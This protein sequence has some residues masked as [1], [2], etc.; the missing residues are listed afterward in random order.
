MRNV[1]TKQLPTKE[2]LQECFSYNDQT[3]ILTRKERP[4][5]HFESVKG[6]KI[7]LKKCQDNP[8]YMGWFDKDNYI[9]FSVTPFGHLLAHRVIFKMLHDREPEQ[10]DHINGKPWDNRP[11]N[12]READS[13]VN[14]RNTKRVTKNKSTGIIGVYL[15]VDERNNRRY[16]ATWFN[17]SGKMNSKSFS[18]NKLGEDVAYDLACKHRQDMINYLN[19]LGAGYTE[20]HSYN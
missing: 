13:F 1:K 17:L 20:R 2:Y 6:W 19:S 15:R 10:I 8:D 12:L 11:N 4:L 14:A 9:R 16:I 5:H 3:G 18:C 7:H